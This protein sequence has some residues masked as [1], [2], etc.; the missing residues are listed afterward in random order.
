MPKIWEGQNTYLPFI[1]LVKLFKLKNSS[2][3]SHYL[4][5]LWTNSS[6]IKRI[7]NQAK[8][9]GIRSLFVSIRFEIDWIVCAWPNIN[10]VPCIVFM[11]ASSVFKL[12]LLV[13]YKPVSYMRN[14]YEIE[15]CIFHS[16]TSENFWLHKKGG[17]FQ[18][19][20]L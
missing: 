1:K 3:I 16:R 4:S 11:L 2:K 18:E 20:K 8:K 17:S 7:V 5:N 9:F 19:S 13:C 15:T 14:F 10:Q 12:H 6:G